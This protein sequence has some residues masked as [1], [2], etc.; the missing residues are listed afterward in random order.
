M[1]MSGIAS[2]HDILPLEIER[3]IIE[4][5]ELGPLD[6]LNLSHVDRAFRVLAARDRLYDIWAKVRER[7]ERINTTH[8][9]IVAFARKPL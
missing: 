1:E 8:L 4:D 9:T 7:F 6:L 2:I 5:G 3:L